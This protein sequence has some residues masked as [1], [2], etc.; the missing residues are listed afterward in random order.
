MKPHSL[1]EEPIDR[2]FTLSLALGRFAK[3]VKRLITARYGAGSLYLRRGEAGVDHSVRIHHL[4]GVRMGF[5]GE[6]RKLHIVR[7]ASYGS[8]A[9]LCGARPPEEE[10]FVKGN[11]YTDDDNLCKTCGKLAVG[12]GF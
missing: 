11:I 7:E 3:Q 4:R 8:R 12:A 2:M 5:A 9:F 10:R 1:L 6:G